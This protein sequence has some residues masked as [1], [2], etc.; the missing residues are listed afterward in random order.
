MA[1]ETMKTNQVPRDNYSGNSGVTPDPLPGTT[2][3]PGTEPIGGSKKP[4]QGQ[5]TPPTVP[6]PKD[7]VDTSSN[8][9]VP[10]H[11]AIVMRDHRDPANWTAEEWMQHIKEDPEKYSALF[12]E[13]AASGKLAEGVDKSSLRD[14]VN[15]QMMLFNERVTSY[16]EFIQA[17]HDTLKALINFHV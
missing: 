9:A 2:I 6:P 8:V 10:A 11:P 5:C 14:F 15:N 13:M 16:H 4:P 3:D 12:F 7:S 17:R 1:G